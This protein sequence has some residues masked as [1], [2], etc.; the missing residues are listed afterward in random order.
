MKNKVTYR[1]RP[2]HQYAL[3]SNLWR[4]YAHGTSFLDCFFYNGTYRFKRK[5]LWWNFFAYPIIFSIQYLAYTYLF[6]LNL[7]LVQISIRFFII[8]CMIIFISIIYNNTYIS[9]LYLYNSDYLWRLF[10]KDQLLNLG[11]WNWIRDLSSR[12]ILEHYTKQLF[13]MDFTIPYEKLLRDEQAVLTLAELFN[14]FSVQKEHISKIYESSNLFKETPKRNRKGKFNLG[15][16]Q[17]DFIHDVK[18]FKSLIKLM[19][20]VRTELGLKLSDNFIDELVSS[21]SFDYE[22]FMF[23]DQYKYY[24][25]TNVEEGILFNIFLARGLQRNI[26]LEGIY[27][28]DL[29][30]SV[31]PLDAGDQ[32]GNINVTN[33]LISFY[34]FLWFFDSSLKHYLPKWFLIKDNIFIFTCPNRKQKND[35]YLCETEGYSFDIVFLIFFIIPIFCYFVGFLFYHKVDFVDRWSSIQEMFLLLK[36]FFSNSFVIFQQFLKYTSINSSMWNSFDESTYGIGYPVINQ[37]LGANR[38][39]NYLFALDPLYNYDN[40]Y[41][42]TQTFINPAILDKIHLITV[43]MVLILFIFN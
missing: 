27:F 32:E 30:Y 43:I 22:R 42:T 20:R 26:Y 40:I 29:D 16:S 5:T 3:Q 15:V 33:L 34:D 1:F 18:K 10:R 36:L 7:A 2:Y 23:D 37:S 6:D 14:N 38:L 19:M 31:M 21:L 13:E 8:I 39:D 12:E 9:A 25:Q 24:F 41:L 35:Y 4:F 28:Q 17:K 11:S